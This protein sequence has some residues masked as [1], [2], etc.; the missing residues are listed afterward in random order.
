MNTNQLGKLDRIFRFLLAFWWLGSWAPQF[1][2]EVINLLI[3]LVGWIALLE[4]FIGK[5]WL[6]RV[7]NIDNRN[8]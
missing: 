6:H 3:A 7:F 8:Q 4:A 5:C 1:D 2:I